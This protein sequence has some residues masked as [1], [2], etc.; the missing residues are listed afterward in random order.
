[1]GCSR[2]IASG[3]LTVVIV[4]QRPGS[5]S[6][7]FASA[8]S[9]E[10]RHVPHALPQEVFWHKESFPDP[11]LDP[12]ACRTTISGSPLCDPDGLLEDSALEKLEQQL[13]KHRSFVPSSC[14]LFDEKGHRPDAG[15]QFSVALVRKVSEC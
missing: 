2:R 6:S 11:L 8:A 14:T 5:P 9:D 12:V 13:L 10:V 15:V 7:L 3:L 1:M 4:G